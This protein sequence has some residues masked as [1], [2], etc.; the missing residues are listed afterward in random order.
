MVGTVAVA[1]MSAFIAF[2]TASELN[3]RVAAS[4]AMVN[5]LAAR[6]ASLL[7][8]REAAEA[9]IQEQMNNQSA[10]AEQLQEY[11][12]TIELLQAQVDE[13]S[14]ELRTFISEN[15]GNTEIREIDEQ[16]G[17]SR[18]GIDRLANG[19]FLV[20][21]TH[22]LDEEMLSRVEDVLF[23]E[24][25]FQKGEINSSRWISS[26]RVFYYDDAAKPRAERIALAMSEILGIE[27]TPIRGESNYSATTII[28]YISL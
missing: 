27:L 5:E 22:N 17:E 10:T 2:F 19:V 18:T 11:E 8:E 13:L 9:R 28:I 25:G 1:L 14:Q 6:T 26:D 7:A 21:V 3:N 20:Q 4:D 24:L 15:P 16:V 12:A 23:D